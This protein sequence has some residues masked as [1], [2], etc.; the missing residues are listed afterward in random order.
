MLFCENK[1]LLCLNF[2]FENFNE[3]LQVFDLLFERGDLT[4]LPG[5]FGFE[6]G[7]L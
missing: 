7:K 5:E 6:Q 1:V 2:I 4:I 3:Q